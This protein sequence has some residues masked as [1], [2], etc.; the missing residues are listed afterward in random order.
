MRG[1]PTRLMYL[2]KKNDAPEEIFT[3]V[4]LTTEAGFRSMTSEIKG[5]T[6]KDTQNVSKI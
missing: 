5:Y 4:R 2:W 3:S 1:I 6:T